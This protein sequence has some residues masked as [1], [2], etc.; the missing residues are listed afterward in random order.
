VTHDDERARMVRTQ[1]EARGIADAR[2]LAAM[3]RVPREAF[4]PDALEPHA[5]EDGP[6][7]IGYDQTIS[8]PY[9]VGLMSEL[10]ALEPGARVLEVGT[11]CG[12]QA[13]VLAELA[14]EVYTIEI[15]ASLARRA[16]ATLRRL[17]YGGVR[18][19]VGDGSRGWPAAA[20]FD[21]IV[22]TAAPERVPASLRD[23]LGPAGR[24]VIPVGGD[25]Q[26]LQVHRRVG[27]GFEVTDVAPVRFVRMTGE[28]LHGRS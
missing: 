3:R 6:L 11:G 9:I 26:V 22:V 17:G 18:V 15:V 5:Y 25:E 23:Q 10:A 13:A 20:P 1:L 28:A 21:A 14:R 8:Q 12:Y 16:E 2:V 7:P 4:V 24:L 19:E 27:D